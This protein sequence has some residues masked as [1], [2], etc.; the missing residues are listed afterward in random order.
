MTYELT[1]TINGTT[2]YGGRD[3]M[4][5]EAAGAL[6]AAYP[7]AFSHLGLSVTED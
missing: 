1:Y 4:L 6:E 7:K 5:A 3:Q 2:A